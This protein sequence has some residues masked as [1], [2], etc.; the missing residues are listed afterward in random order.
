MPN[1]LIAITAHAPKSSTA[2]HLADAQP[3][4]HH[5]AAITH[6]TARLKNP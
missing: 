1:V 2:P 3:Q 6:P 5:P 4:L